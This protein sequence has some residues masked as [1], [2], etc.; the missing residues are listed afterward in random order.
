MA[1][2]VGRLETNERGY[3]VGV[4]ALLNG[5]AEGCVSEMFMEAMT[6]ETAKAIAGELRRVA[7]RIESKEGAW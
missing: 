2:Q 5:A 1:D 7:D 6:R 4:V 3:L